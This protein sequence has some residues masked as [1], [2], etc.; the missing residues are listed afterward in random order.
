MDFESAIVTAAM[1]TMLRTM[2]RKSGGKLFRDSQPMMVIG[3]NDYGT[4]TRTSTLPGCS[5]QELT[6]FSESGSATLTRSD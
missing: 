5:T 4:A 3:K 6:D 1:A 2:L